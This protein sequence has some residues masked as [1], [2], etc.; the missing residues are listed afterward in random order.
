MLHPRTSLAILHGQANGGSREKI[1]Y[2]ARYLVH[3]DTIDKVH[4]TGATTYRWSVKGDVL[5]FRWLEST[6]P[7]Y[8]GIRDEVFPRALYMTQ[9]FKRRGGSPTERGARTR[10]AALAEPLPLAVGDAAR[11]APTPAPLVSRTQ[12]FSRTSR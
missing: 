11:A 4:G 9:P 7:A 1:D 2:D 12:G 3:G 10:Q 5:S 6:E 8:R